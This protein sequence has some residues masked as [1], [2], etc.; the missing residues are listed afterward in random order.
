MNLLF[1]HWKSSHVGFQ[2]IHYVAH[3]SN[4]TPIDQKLTWIMCQ[5][6]SLLM[7]KTTLLDFTSR[8]T[9]SNSAFLYDHNTV[10]FPQDT[11]FPYLSFSPLLKKKTTLRTYGFHACRFTSLSPFDGVGFI[12]LQ[13]HIHC[14]TLFTMELMKL[15]TAQS[16]T[17]ETYFSSVLILQLPCS[18]FDGVLLLVNQPIA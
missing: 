8:G 17:M 15:F 5:V 14:D 18:P 13:P 16:N 12:I 3:L 10:L 11:V 2:Y 9:V 6:H 1:Q 4:G 7:K